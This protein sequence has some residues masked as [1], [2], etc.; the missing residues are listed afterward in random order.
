MQ[1]RCPALAGFS[2]CRLYVISLCL[3]INGNI[4]IQTPRRAYRKKQVSSIGGRMAFN[5]FQ[6]MIMPIIPTVSINN[7]QRMPCG[8]VLFSTSKNMRII[9]K[10]HRTASIVIASSAGYNIVKNKIMIISKAAY[11]IADL[12]DRNSF[13]LSY[14]YLS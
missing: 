14:K 8:S 13:K 3:I 12:A 4:A 11:P 9:L 7:F 6:M 2:T 5:P 10:P 1:R